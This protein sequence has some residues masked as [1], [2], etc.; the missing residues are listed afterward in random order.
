MNIKVI[1]SPAGQIRSLLKRFFE[2]LTQNPEFY[3][4]KHYTKTR[5]RYRSQKAR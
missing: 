2:R 3:N 5:D 4:I 1:T